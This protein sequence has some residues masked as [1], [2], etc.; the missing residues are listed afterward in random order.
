MIAKLYKEAGRLMKVLIA[1]TEHMAQ[2]S[3]H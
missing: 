2:V 3:L 1:N